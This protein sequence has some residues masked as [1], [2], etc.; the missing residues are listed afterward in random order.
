MVKFEYFNLPSKAIKVSDFFGVHIDCVPPSFSQ[1]LEV[2]LGE[3]WTIAKDCV[4]LRFGFA[5]RE[6]IGSDLWQ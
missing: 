2:F 5:H 4:Q 6:N 1:L 3:L